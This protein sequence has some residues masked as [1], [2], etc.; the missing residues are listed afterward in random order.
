[1]GWWKVSTTVR[2]LS[3]ATISRRLLM[4]SSWNPRCVAG[5]FWWMMTPCFAST[6]N[7]F[8]RE[9]TTVPALRSG[10]KPQRKMNLRF[11]SL[12]LM[13]LSSGILIRLSW[14]PNTRISSDWKECVWRWIINL[15]RITNSRMASVFR[16]LSRVCSKLTN[17]G[18]SGWCPV[19]CGKSVSR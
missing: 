5:I 12:T 16:C 2:R 9:Y 17:I 15:S 13:R 6:T 18:L 3:I 1:M 11:C 10:A 19:C 14:K 7:V 8:P 4:S